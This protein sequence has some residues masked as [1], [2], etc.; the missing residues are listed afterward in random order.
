[1]EM[2]ASLTFRSLMLEFAFAS[3]AFD[4]SLFLINNRLFSSPD[5]SSSNP[6]NLADFNH[7]DGNCHVAVSCVWI[8]CLS[9][10]KRDVHSVSF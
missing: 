6:A 9:V 3:C 10:S 4:F 2:T 7:S 8:T 5:A 1:M